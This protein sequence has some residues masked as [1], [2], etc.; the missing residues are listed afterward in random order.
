M[1]FAEM[2]W[3]A[4]IVGTV[5]GFLAG[6]LF[7]SP[8]LFGRKWAEGSGVTLNTADKMPVQAMVTQLLA[9]LAL[10]IVVGAA[11]AANALPTA[12]FAILAAALFVASNG[13]F[14]RKSSYAIAVDAGYICVA[15]VIMILIQ[16]VL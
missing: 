11:A 4:V 2:N 14:C 12:I 15:G 8:M 6:W 16:A 7:Y 1:A 13:G 9:L 5:I 3:L 10:S